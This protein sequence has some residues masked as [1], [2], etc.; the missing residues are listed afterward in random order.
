MSV[1]ARKGYA[2]T[3]ILELLGRLPK[4]WAVALTAGYVAVLGWVDF[5]T[6]FDLRLS[7]FYLVPAC[8]MTWAI[9]RRAGL[10]CAVVCASMQGWMGH[11]TRLQHVHPMTIFWNAV[12]V[13]VTLGVTVYT[14]SA[15][16]DAYRRLLKAQASLRSANEGLEGLVRERTSALR[17]EIAERQ[18]TEEARIQA[19]RLLER[20]EKLA[21]LGT[22]TAGIAHE[23]RN[24]LTSLKARLY[25]LEKHLDDAPLARRDT[26]IIA[27]EIDRL[28]RVV[29]E[30]LSFARPAEP[31]F[32]AIEVV[33][34]LRDVRDL[35]SSGTPAITW[36]LEGS[37]RGIKVRAD[38]G[39]MKQVLIN[40]VR[41]AMEAVG[42][43]GTVTLRGV[44]C[45][46]V[47]RGSEAECVRIEIADTGPGIPPEVERRLY[48]PFFSTKE[49]G[50]GL[51]LATAARIVEQH[52]G[53]LEHRTR[54]GEGTT[55]VVVLPRVTEP[56]SSE[57]P[58]ERARGFG[59]RPSR[60]T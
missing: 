58:A 21:T 4:G 31:V 44:P 2:V 20:R 7:G 35:I 29:N 55:F 50:T 59:T 49:H 5:V 45:R 54:V 18:R 30:A 12:M 10:G 48:D 39:H 9:G 57:A 6:G 23:I 42:E 26:D 60:E 56:V 41:N 43:S 17:A 22:L 32:E 27:S 16:I 47:S 14:L 13:L 11:L 28:E 15:A 1:D 3:R 51:G 36:R 34:L 52:G 40:L 8:W 24:P 25:T 46:V 19:E 33:P 37:E 38:R 53:R